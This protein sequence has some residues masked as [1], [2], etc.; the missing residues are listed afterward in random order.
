MTGCMA[1]VCR[2]SGSTCQLCSQ[3]LQLHWCVNH[4]YRRHS[5]PLVACARTVH[6]CLPPGHLNKDLAAAVQVR[7]LLASA[8]P[9]P[10]VLHS[11]PEVGD[12]EVQAL[13]QAKLLALSFRTMALPLGRGALTLGE[14]GQVWTCA[15]LQLHLVRHA[16]APEARASGQ[17]WLPLGW[18]CQR[19]HATS[20]ACKALGGAW[21]TPQ[22]S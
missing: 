5:C 17:W 11:T 20:Q 4:R 3:A 1:H 12:V 2:R 21:H 9:T 8:N 14:S 22:L 16:H 18:C 19:M 15:G 7:C 13:Q 10:V 6:A